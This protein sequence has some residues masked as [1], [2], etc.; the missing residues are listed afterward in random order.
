[1]SFK[2]ERFVGE[3]NATVLR[4][5]GRMNMEC[6]NT[7]KKLSEKENVR[8][9]FDLSEVTIASRDAAIF[10]AV[11]ELIGNELR[12]CPPFLRE[13]VTKEKLRISP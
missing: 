1:M 6:V 3:K 7:I 13:W 5:C 12:N 4:V 11:S 2:I 10:L 9:T 8:I